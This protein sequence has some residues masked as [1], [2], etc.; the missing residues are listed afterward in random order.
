MAYAVIVQKHDGELEFE[1]GPDQ[2]TVFVIRL[3]VEAKRIK[4]TVS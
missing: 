2:G 4:E 1:A 3:P